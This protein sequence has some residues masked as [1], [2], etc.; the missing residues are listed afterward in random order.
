MKTIRSYSELVKIKNFKDRILYLRTNSPV[1]E[2]TFAGHRYLNQKFYKSTDWHRIRRKII[3]RD[4]GFDLGHSDYPISGDIYV[5]HINPVTIEDIL[6]MRQCVYDPEN[7]ISASFRTHNQIHYGIDTLEFAE[8][9]VRTVNDT[10]PW[11]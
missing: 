1:G 5:H 7:L 10:C 9:V 8:S 6:E 11:R 2:T 4:N 3:L